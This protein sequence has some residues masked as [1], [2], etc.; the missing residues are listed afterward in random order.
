MESQEVR[1]RHYCAYITLQIVILYRLHGEVDMFFK[2]LIL[3]A[4]LEA[5]FVHG[6]IFNY[7]DINK[8]FA[9]DAL[10]T[11]LEAS[12]HY[13]ALYV[14]GAMDCYFTPL[15]LTHFSPFQMTYIFRAGLE[16]GNVKLEYEHS[17][18]HPMQPYATIIG[19][20]IKPKYEGGYDRV[21]IRIAK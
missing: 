15:D 9:F 10:Y 16:S 3:C 14:G 18:F 5:G 11:T 8:S 21:Y 13:K 19:N 4:A 17:C 2:A 6:G 7:S 12:L 1:R 20:E